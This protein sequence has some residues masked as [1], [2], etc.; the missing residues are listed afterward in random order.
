MSVIMNY[1]ILTDNLNLITNYS[2]LITLKIKKRIIRFSWLQ[3]FFYIKGSKLF[4]HNK[5][6]FL[7]L[8]IDDK[9]IFYWINPVQSEGCGWCFLAPTSI[10]ISFTS[11]SKT[12]SL[13]FLFCTHLYTFLKY[14]TCSISVFLLVLHFIQTSQS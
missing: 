8:H 13:S 3:S 4:R 6:N 12:I 11:F 2:Y 14:Y 1:K 10:K 9:Q 5:C 7:I